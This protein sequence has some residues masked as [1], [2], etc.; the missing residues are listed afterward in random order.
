MCSPAI[1]GIAERELSL[2]PE[3]IGYARVRSPIKPIPMDLL[4]ETPECAVQKSQE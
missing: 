4:L 2:K 3:R 1:L